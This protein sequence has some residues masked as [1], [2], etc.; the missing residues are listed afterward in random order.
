MRS[1]GIRLSR[2]LDDL[3]QFQ[4][5]TAKRVRLDLDH[6]CLSFTDPVCDVAESVAVRDGRQ[7]AIF[8]RACGSA[9]SLPTSV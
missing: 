5:L 8:G 4:E 7:D 9:H 6:E 1:V 3:G 2:N